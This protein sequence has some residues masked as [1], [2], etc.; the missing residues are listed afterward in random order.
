[1][2]VYWIYMI[3]NASNSAI[4][5]VNGIETSIGAPPSVFVQTGAARQ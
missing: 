3:E 2:I 5:M 1:M 4:I